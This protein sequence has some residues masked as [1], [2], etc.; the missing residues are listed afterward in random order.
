[1]LG[2][3][4]PTE[5]VDKKQIENTNTKLNIAETFEDPIFQEYL[6][7][8]YDE[9]ED[10]CL[11]EKE[12]SQITS[13]RMNGFQEEKYQSLKSISG[14][15][16]FSEL[17]DLNCYGSGLKKIDISKNVNL[18]K[19][20]LGYTELQE[21]DVSNNPEL[22]ELDCDSTNVT[23]LDVSHNPK[24][25][26]LSCSRTDIAELDISNNKLLEDLTIDETNIEEINVE[27]LENLKYL[28]C[29]PQVKEIDLKNNK[30]LEGLGIDYTEISEIDLSENKNLQVFDCTGAS[31]LKELDLSN[32]PKLETIY[33][34]K[35]GIKK[36]DLSNNPKVFE[37]DCNKD[38]VI[39]GEEQLT[40]LGRE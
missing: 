10:G 13:I 33:C 4:K 5:P 8:N 29:P 15:E 25:Q 24:L 23:H 7:E 17:K 2:C 34:V 27:E 28:N 9:N 40:F 16:Y 6:S 1:M 22:L 38:T 19:V 3:D 37:V 36:L 32:N 11:S 20:I 30:K 14:I 31:N 21:I 35:S 12:I 26:V 39:I 18:E